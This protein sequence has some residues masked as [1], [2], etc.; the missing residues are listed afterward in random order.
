[1]ITRVA[2][3]DDYGR[4]W[5]LPK[6]NRHGDVLK[7]VRQDTAISHD[8]K[9]LEC[10]FLNHLGEFKDRQ[11][12]WFDAHENGQILPPYNPINPQQRCGTP[13][14]IPAELFSEDI[15]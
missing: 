8:W 14:D 13:S 5:S 11:E 15:W 1:M 3:K 4:I 2:I 6:P 10:G 9:Q 12:A 7:L